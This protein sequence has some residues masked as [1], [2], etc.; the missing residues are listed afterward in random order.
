[1]EINNDAIVCEQCG[2]TELERKAWVDYYTDQVLDDTGDYDTST[3]W[4]RK[5]EE[6]VEFIT[7]EQ[8][9]NKI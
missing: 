8:F 6:H 9:K 4:C 2:G 1:M 7:Y 3:N 5:C